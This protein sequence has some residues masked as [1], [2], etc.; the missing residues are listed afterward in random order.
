MTAPAATLDALLIPLTEAPAEARVQFRTPQG[1]IGAGAH[2]TELKLAQV[3]SIDC[4]GRLSDWT[5]AQLQLLDSQTGTPLTAGKI[6]DILHRSAQAL[7]GLLTAA[8]SIE[9]APGNHG[10]RRYRI[11]SVQATGAQIVVD[12]APEHAQCK[13]AQ[14]AS[15]SCCGAGPAQAACCG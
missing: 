8:L 1:E 10:L 7:P 14:Q 2:L 4:G 11:G 3:S 15:L 12:L 9:A 13:P 5:E 6:A